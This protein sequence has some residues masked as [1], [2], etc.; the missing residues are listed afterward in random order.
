MHEDLIDIAE[1]MISHNYSSLFVGEEH[2]P[3]KPVMAAVLG[4][5]TDASTGVARSTAVLH[6]A[7]AHRLWEGQDQDEVKHCQLVVDKSNRYWKET[8][9]Y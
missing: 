5:V 2:V 3:V 4:A 1:V 9:L 6:I 8:L 7:A